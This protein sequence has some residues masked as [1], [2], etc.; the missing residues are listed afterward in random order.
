M[1]NASYLEA[2]ENKYG[3]IQITDYSFS[4]LRENS[5]LLVE[6]FSFELNDVTE[7]LGNQ[8]YF[9]PMLFLATES[10]SLKQELCN[11]PIDFSYPKNERY[12]ITINLPEL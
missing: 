2:L 1:P 12:I 6:T 3:G 10:H 9:N 5:D 11:Y 7:S 4:G 8:I